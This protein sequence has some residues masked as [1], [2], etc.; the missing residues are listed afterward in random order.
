MAELKFKCPN[1]G[2]IPQEDVV[3]L[4]NH[5]KQDEL[6]YKDGVYM[7]PQCFVP[8]DNFECMKCESNKV[9]L[10]K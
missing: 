4:C 8:G 9:I 10:I 7:C 5:C 6:V 1:C 3:F 2:I